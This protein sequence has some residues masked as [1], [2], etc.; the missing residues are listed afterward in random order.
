VSEDL[1]A[2]I[3]DQTS[4]E[5]MSS[6]KERF[7]DNTEKIRVKNAKFFR[8]GKVGDWKNFFTE[9]QNRRF[10]EAYKTKMAGSGLDFDFT[11]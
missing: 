4:F 11:L 6:T 9:E 2:R 8:K 5:A 10:D 1:I 7:Y 3:A